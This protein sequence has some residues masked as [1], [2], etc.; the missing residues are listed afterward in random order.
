MDRNGIV[1]AP[2]AIVAT[3]EIKSLTSGVLRV[4]YRPTGSQLEHLTQSNGPSRR[5]VGWL[6]RFPDHF[7]LFKVLTITYLPNVTEA[8]VILPAFL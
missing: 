1:V 4:A 2:V 6:V 8:H 3:H 7:G 5:V